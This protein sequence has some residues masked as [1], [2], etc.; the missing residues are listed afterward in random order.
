MSDG[1]LCIASANQ[2]RMADQPLGL[3][4]ESEA[5]LSKYR[6]GPNTA[7]WAAVVPIA[8]PQSCLGAPK[9]LSVVV[10]AAEDGAKERIS[11]RRVA[12]ALSFEA[13]HLFLGPTFL[14]HLGD[15]F[16]CDLYRIDLTDYRSH[17]H[18]C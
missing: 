6:N 5:E 16:R 7:H 9:V 2:I 18:H 13:E 11:A 10:L 14:Y 3:L 17:L 15:D 12:I 8:S 4:S 1:N